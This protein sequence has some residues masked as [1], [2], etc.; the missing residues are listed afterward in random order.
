MT[1]LTVKVVEHVV[2]LP[3]ASVAVRVTVV[4]PAATVDPASGDWV[5]VMPF[6]AQLSSATTPGT[7]FGTIAAQLASAFADWA[8]AQVVIV[9]AVV[10]AIV[11]VVVHVEELPTASVAVR[12]TVYVP[13]KSGVPMAGDCVSVTELQLSLTDALLRTSGR[14]AAQNELTETV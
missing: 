6:S 9:G 13:V 7:K 3:A 8:V 4:T 10:S 1:S 14:A 2:V 12:V 5:T 11:T